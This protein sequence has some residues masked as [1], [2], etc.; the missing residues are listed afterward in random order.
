ME[1]DKTMPATAK[2]VGKDRAQIEFNI[3][4]L[5]N[6]LKIDRGVES[7]NCNGCNGCGHIVEKEQ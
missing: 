7:M 6:Q 5:A 4:D 3:D 1:E 2:V